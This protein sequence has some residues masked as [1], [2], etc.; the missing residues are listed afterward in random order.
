MKNCVLWSPFA[1]SLGHGS[2]AW[3][4]PAGRRAMRA[5]SPPRGCH[6]AAVPPRRGRAFCTW[7]FLYGSEM[8][9]SRNESRSAASLGVLLLRPYTVRLAVV[10]TAHPVA[11]PP[12][13]SLAGQGAG[14]A[15]R[16]KGQPCCS[17]CPLLPLLLTSWPLLLPDS[18]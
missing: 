4:S 10:F 15:A 12:A 11:G 6:R 3:L 18:F 1:A 7:G 5:G 2:L 14:Q 9:C 13:P 16:E 8:R 17:H